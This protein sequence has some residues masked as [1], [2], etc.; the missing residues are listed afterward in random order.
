MTTTARPSEPES[1]LILLANA[2]EALRGTRAF[3]GNFGEEAFLSLLVRYCRREGYDLPDEPLLS[4]D[5]M[6]ATIRRF[7]E[8]QARERRRREDWRGVG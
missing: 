8:E 7:V 4:R 5:R 2:L 1:P 3:R 6:R